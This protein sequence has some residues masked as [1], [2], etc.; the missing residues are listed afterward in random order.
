MMI[1]SSLASAAR[2]ALNAR[3]ARAFSSSGTAVHER[4]RP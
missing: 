2:I 4:R 3:A 1:D